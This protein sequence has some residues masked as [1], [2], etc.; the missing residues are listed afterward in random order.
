M[1]L[2]GRKKTAPAAAQAA[3]IQHPMEAAN[4]LAKQQETLMKRQDYLEKQMHSLAAQALERNKRGDK[5]GEA[6]RNEGLQLP[7][8][9]K[10]IRSKL[11]PRR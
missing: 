8:S 9:A 10:S 7:T 6:P 5:R 2:F 11:R 4:N 3:A 1:N